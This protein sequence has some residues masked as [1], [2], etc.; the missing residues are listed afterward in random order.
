MKKNTLMAMCAVFLFASTLYAQTSI[1]S[2]ETKE[3]Y[4]A[5]SV[6]TNGIASKIFVPHFEK[7]NHTEI[8]GTMGLLTVHKNDK[9]DGYARSLNFGVG[10]YREL[11]LGAYLKSYGIIPII[12]FPVLS[13][14]TME[15]IDDATTI[16][17][18]G[19]P[20]FVSFDAS[21][22]PFHR[23]E[24]KIVYM[25]LRLGR[26][27]WV[28]VSQ[29]KWFPYYDGIEI[30][31]QQKTVDAGIMIAFAVPL[32]RTEYLFAHLGMGFLFADGK[33]PEFIV[34]F[35]FTLFGRHAILAKS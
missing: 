24:E 33:K 21:G 22:L 3:H 1:V 26:L 7:I 10:D 11:M 20:L 12:K 17:R 5:D 27:L 25:R 28:G 30:N 16:N 6:A 13:F 23:Q 15:T 31:I 34:R 35:S 2:F 18:F 8:I 19:A 32:Q 9:Y 14:F 4:I 29:N